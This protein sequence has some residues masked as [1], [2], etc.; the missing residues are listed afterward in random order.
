MHNP[1][2]PALVFA[3]PRALPKAA[4]LEGRVVVLDIAFAA[5]SSSKVSFERV[6]LKLINALGDRLAA[7]VDHHDHDKHPDFAEDERF[8]LCTKAQHGAC[9]EMISPEL[10]RASGPIDTIVAHLDLDG[11]YS[12]A[13]WI[14][15]GQEPYKG[16][17]YD[18]RCIDTRTGEP[19]P[20]AVKIDRALR[21]RFRDEDL[22]RA[23]V[24]WLVEG[25]RKGVH[26][27]VIDE[28]EREFDANNQGT[29]ALAARYQTRGRVV[30]VDASG[31]K[32]P[33]DKTELLLIGQKQAAIAA[34]VDCGSVTFAAAFDSGWNFIQILGLEGGMPTRVSV[35]E[36]RLE[37]AIAAINAAEEPLAQ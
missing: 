36:S 14:L 30:V 28:A 2:T 22:K 34:V 12:A 26:Q 13:K 35:S 29:D 6:T 32:V 27:E 11:L 24:L 19:G 20:I 33:Y 7:W 1:R 15:E 5:T 16:A 25:R 23:V 17:D 21:A 18:A 9:P 10:V 31:S 37:E 8:T 4:K 3:S